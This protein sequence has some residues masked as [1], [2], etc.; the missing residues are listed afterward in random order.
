MGQS[1]TLEHPMA[2]DFLERDIS[3]LARYF[4]KRYAIG[5]EEAIKEKIRAGK[6]G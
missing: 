6:D 5:S 4:K 2:R 1:V 3:N